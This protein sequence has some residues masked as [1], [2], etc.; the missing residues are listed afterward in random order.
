MGEGVR[1]GVSRRSLEGYAYC[2]GVLQF[3]GALGG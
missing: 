2:G 1:S 3:P